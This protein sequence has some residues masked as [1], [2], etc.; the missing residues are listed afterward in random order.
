MTTNIL[1]N[2]TDTSVVMNSSSL[3]RLLVAI[4]LLFSCLAASVIQLDD[5]TFEHDTQA[6]T[7]ST[8]GDW[9]V[10]FYAP[11][12]G[13][14]QRLAPDWE[15]LANTLE[16]KI[17]V[18]EVDC[19]TNQVTCTRFEIGGYPTLLFFKDGKYYKYSGP[20]TVE[21]MAKFATVSY[22]DTEPTTVPKAG[23]TLLEMAL[24]KVKSIPAET[25]VVYQTSKIG[26]AAILIM[27]ACIGAILKGCQRRCCMKN[28]RPKQD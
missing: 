27:G 15:S 2:R 11:W 4:P 22:A 1:V 12:C 21:D 17:N 26:S 19:T 18:A 10:K 13:H 28:K 25:Y 5:L 6:S 23:Y 24:N 3:L 14:C 9:F 7:G 20:R 16:G 8:T